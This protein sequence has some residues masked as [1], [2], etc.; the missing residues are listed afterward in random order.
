MKIELHEVRV[1]R[2]SK[3]K[4]LDPLV[5]DFNQRGRLRM[6]RWKPHCGYTRPNATAL[7]NLPAGGIAV[8]DPCPGGF[9]EVRAKK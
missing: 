3:I 9:Y 2:W 5:V 7:E 4:K 1:H 8:I 6:A